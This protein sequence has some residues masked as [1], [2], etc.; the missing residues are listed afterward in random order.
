MC[1]SYIERCPSQ[2]EGVS[3]S[4]DLK[5]GIFQIEKECK[6]GKPSH[7]ELKGS[8]MPGDKGACGKQLEMR[9]D[10]F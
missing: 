3:A 1:I 7:T 9:P 4:A 10:L 2:G 8:D 5:R 6:T